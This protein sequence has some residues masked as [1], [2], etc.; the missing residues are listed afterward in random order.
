[1]KTFRTSVEEFVRAADWLGPVD[2]PEVTALRV[3]ADALDQGI[4]GRTAVLN[5]YGLAVRSLIKRRPP[6][7]PEAPSD[8]LSKA[9]ADA[10][11]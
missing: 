8:P 9:M 6:A 4:E 11:L 1:M 7:A 10:G 3:M 5:A 2:E